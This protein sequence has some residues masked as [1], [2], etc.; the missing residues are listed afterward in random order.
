MSRS[1]QYSY[2]LEA[3]RRRAIYNEQVSATTE[4]FYRQYLEKYNQM[5]QNGFMLYIPEEMKRLKSDLE[6]IRDFLTSN[7]IEARDISYEVGLYIR[8][9]SSLANTAIAQFEREER[10]R[11]EKLEEE[12]KNQQNERIELYF[13]LLQEMTNPI[14]INFSMS[15]LQQLRKE[16]EE[17]KVESKESIQTTVQTIVAKAEKKA[18]EWKEQ[19]ILANR[20]KDIEENLVEAQNYIQNENI[21][22]KNTTD[23]FIKKI[24]EL[25]QQLRLEN[26]DYS[27]VEQQISQIKTEVEDT[28]ITEE[29][30]RET[31]K[32]II[33]QLKS[34]EFIVEKPQITQMEDKNYVKIVAKKPSGKRAVCNVDLHGKIVYKFDNY[35][36]MTCLKEIEKF[37]VDLEQ[38]YSI[39]L[40]DERVL[41]SNPDK[42]SKDMQT[43]PKNNG[44]MV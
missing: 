24:N 14:V 36:G 1:Y 35:E 42:I 34:Q 37:N 17:G 15:E 4:K 3:A 5:E 31:V 7:P 44:R 28:L 13:E 12:K 16:I 21:E 41:W 2:G 26:V 32:A 18:E 19:T 40:S 11:I 23:E 25:K 8:S 30:R 33:K 9:M 29:V 22:N 6:Q 20:K 10:M 38:I 39:K 43:I 27:V